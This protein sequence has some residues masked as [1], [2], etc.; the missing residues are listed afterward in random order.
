MSRLTLTNPFSP[1]RYETSPGSIQTANSAGKFSKI[2]AIGT[3]LSRAALSK[4]ASVG[5]PVFKHLKAE[6]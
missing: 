5:S 2:S 4:T 3:P 1:I 6:P